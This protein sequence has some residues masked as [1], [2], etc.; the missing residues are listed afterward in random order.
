VALGFGVDIGGTGIKAGLVDLDTGTLAG[1]R[2][3]VPTPRGGE[4]EAVCGLVRD[5]V[6]AAGWTGP[7]GVAFPAVVQHGIAL[8]AANIDPRWIGM[9]VR[10]AITAAT[11]TPTTVLNDADAAGLAEVRFGAG[12]GV[13]GVVL[14]L[15]LGTGI[16]SAL[17]TDGVLVPNTELGHLEIDGHDAEKRAAESAREREGLDWA[18]WAARLEHYLHRVDSLL[19]P[20]L[21]VLGGGAAR[22]SGKW[23]SLLEVRPRLEVASLRNAAGIVGAAMGSAGTPNE[24]RH[25]FSG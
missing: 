5:L 4:P 19:W 24:S 22:K 8:T 13:D 10:A 3:R 23:L 25:D 16:G 12:A 14:V 21:V 2:V 6:T 1:E 7:L 15:T 18:T 11:G 17:F 9:D 20:D